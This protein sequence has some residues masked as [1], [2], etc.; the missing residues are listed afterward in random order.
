MSRGGR[1]RGPDMVC[2][3]RLTRRGTR[4]RG[5]IVHQI[6][7]RIRRARIARGLTRS[8]LAEQAELPVR[9]PSRYE[10]QSATPGSDVLC[11]LERALGVKV[12]YFLRPR[13]VEVTCVPRGARSLPKREWAKVEW[14]TAEY[15]ERYFAVEELLGLDRVEAFEWPAAASGGNA[16]VEQMESSA[17]CVR[18]G[19]N[20][21]LDPIANLCETL[22]D[23][24]VKVVPLEDAPGGVLASAC[25]ADDRQPVVAV[26][27]GCEV[28]GD[29]QRFA[30]AREL[31]R[32]MFGGRLAAGVSVERACDRFA[33]ALLVPRDSVVR[34][35]G[36]RR[37]ELGYRELLSLRRKW[38]LGML[39]WYRRLRDL[40]VISV[41]HRRSVVHAFRARGW[42]ESEPGDRLEPDSPSRFERLVHRAVAEDVIGPS[43]AG[44]LL[45]MPLI[46]VRRELCWPV[47]E[48]P[49]SR[50]R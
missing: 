50:T 40:G 28:T 26:H 5:T 39:E 29:R 3:G 14:T 10:A 44:D 8:D 32:L 35:V 30:V 42:H 6:G 25:W 22:E 49:G 7:E 41:S 38:G 21:G 45:A 34:E 18:H 12:G 48:S 43:R 15:L 2:R 37:S 24:G 31:G 1:E 27:T 16:R 46:D 47:A 13:Q 17:E 36:E 19:W 11:R 9:D 4:E 20:L 33:G 23:H